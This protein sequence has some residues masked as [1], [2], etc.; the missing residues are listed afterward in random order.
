MPFLFLLVFSGSGCE[1]VSTAVSGEGDGGGDSSDLGSIEVSPPGPIT[2]GFFEEQIF[3]LLLLD[4]AGYPL[5][6][7]PVQA[8]LI[9]PAHNGHLTPFELT[10]DSQGRGQL[11]FSAPD[12]E[13]QLEIRFSSPAASDDASVDVFVEPDQLSI[14]ADVSYDGQRELA[15]FEARLYRD[16]S[17]EDVAGSEPVA[18]Q[19]AQQPASFDF[20]G[21]LSGS[22]YALLGVGS[23]E[24]GAPRAEACVDGLAPDGSS[25]SLALEDL[26]LEPAGVFQAEI[27]VETD[28]ALSPAIGELAGGM[29]DFA[30]DVPGAILD[31]IRDELSDSIAEQQFDEVRATENLDEIVADDLDARGVD[32]AAELDAAQSGMAQRL[33]VTTMLSTLEIG[34]ESAGERDFYHRI[35]ALEFQGLENPLQAALPDTGEGTAWLDE[36]NLDLLVLGQ[37]QVGLALGTPLRHLLEVELAGGEPAQN[38]AVSLEQIVDCDAVSAVLAS[39]LEGVATPT[40]ILA[41]CE[42]AMIDA[43]VMADQQQALISA[44]YGQLFFEQGSCALSDPGAGDQVQSLV[45]GALQIVW[46]GGASLGPMSATFGG[47]RIA[48][49]Q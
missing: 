5:A 33:A 25:V 35:D 30:G 42:A 21:L 26:A 10:T 36:D 4:G 37:H 23:N 20:A 16:V 27:A 3:D 6:D 48:D 7:E 14:T 45:D 2:L 22:T 41:G 1:G 43:R 31:A 18:Q 19:S 28:G 29:D 9:G 44:S 24:A 49:E 39:P 15:L 32:V 46:G 34:A 38:L 17:C 12:Q 13:A 47:E 8:S 40:T 11:V